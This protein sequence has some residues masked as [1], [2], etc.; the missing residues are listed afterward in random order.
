MAF[1]ICTTFYTDIAE[2][3]IYFLRNYRNT[4]VCFLY[5]NLLVVDL[6][7]KYLL[8]DLDLPMPSLLKTLFMNLSFLG[9]ACLLEIFHM[10]VLI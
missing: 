6:G 10:I 2:I 1:V 7:L 8:L 4:V 9:G 5:H 3:I